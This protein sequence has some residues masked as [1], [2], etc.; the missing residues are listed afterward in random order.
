MSADTSAETIPGISWGDFESPKQ[1][2]IALLEAALPPVRSA[3]D[4]YRTPPCDAGSLIKDRFLDRG[5][6]MLLVGPSGVGKSTFTAGLCVS[7]ASGKEYLGITPAGS[8]KVLVIQAENDDGDLHEQLQGAAGAPLDSDLEEVMDTR[9]FFATVDALSGD[10]FL[11]GMQIYL[12][13]HHPDVVVL[14][15]LSAYLGDSPTEPKAIINFL[16]NGLTPLLRKYSCGAIIVHHTPKTTNQDRSGWTP[17]DLQYAAAGCADV[18]NWA[19]AGILIQATAFPDLFRLFATKRGARLR[20]ENERGKP[21]TFKLIRHSRLDGFH[22]PGGR[23]PLCWELADEKDYARLLGFESLKKGPP[24]VTR[25]P[26]MFLD[27]LPEA[28]RG[29]LSC[30]LS[31]QIREKLKESGI[32]PKDSYAAWRQELE[33]QNHVACLKVGKETLIGR[34]EDI[35]VVRR[36]LAAPPLEAG[37]TSLGVRAQKAQKSPVRKGDVKKKAPAGRRHGASKTEKSRP[38]KTDP[39]DASGRKKSNK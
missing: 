33:E 4:I 17:S 16:R 1:G 15:C 7:L 30:L 2:E 3:L 27:M 32:C 12:E 22:P 11:A 31:V 35:E 9:L 8:F 29:R 26:S 20:W 36:S 28:G 18:M 25:T 19:R 5:G 38:Q 34:P 21:A 13:K 24:K 37:E 14:D 23:P 10:N 39:A 6:G